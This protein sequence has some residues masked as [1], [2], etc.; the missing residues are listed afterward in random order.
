MHVT[1]SGDH[2]EGGLHTKALRVCS[3]GIVLNNINLYPLFVPKRVGSRYD[4]L[5]FQPP[6]SP[7]SGIVVAFGILLERE[8]ECRS[9]DW[10]Y[11]STIGG[12]TIHMHFTF[13]RTLTQG[14]VARKTCRPRPSASRVR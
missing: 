5:G 14:C 6:K 3:F 10:A 13:R 1:P 7:F 4:G 2:P 9:L 11:M 8:F 12:L